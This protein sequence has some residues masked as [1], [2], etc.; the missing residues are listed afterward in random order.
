[1]KLY[2]FAV[3]VVA[4][5]GCVVFLLSCNSGS[6]ST[7]EDNHPPDN[8]AIQLQAYSGNPV[9]SYDVAQILQGTEW[10]Q[11]ALHHAV[12]ENGIDGWIEDT[13]PIFV[14]TDFS[15]TQREMRAPHAIIDG[16]DVMMW[17]A[18][19]DFL[20]RQVSGIG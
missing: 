6:G 14:Y 19:D 11:V 12:S 17:F 10:I 2:K 3:L 5:I 1:M 7:S 9:I 4:I 18:G 8:M 20:A 16:T 13:R 15:W